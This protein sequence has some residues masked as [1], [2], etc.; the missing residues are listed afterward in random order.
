MKNFSNLKK[1]AKYFH[2]HKGEIFIGSIFLALG[3]FIN[4][5]LPYFFKIV[6]DDGIFDISNSALLNLL[7]IL[8]V[9][10][11]AQSLF[12]YFRHLYFHNVAHKVSNKLRN[13]VFSKIIFKKYDF[14]QN[15]KA[16]DLVSLISSDVLNIQK[17]LTINSSVILR[18]SFQVI[19]SIVLM[20][21]ISP[22]LSLILIS[23]IPVLAII[24]FGLAKRLS[25]H[26]N[27]LQN[28]I[29]QINDLAH[30]S[31]S[32]ITN[33]KFLLLEKNRI[34]TFTSSVE[35]LLNIAIK[36]TRFA[37]F[38]S[39]FMVFLVHSSVAIVILIGIYRVNI[40]SMSVGDL[41]AFL[42]YCLILAMSF[43]FII[44]GFDDLSTAIASS[45][46]IFDV[47]DV[48]ENDSAILEDIKLDY[49]LP[50]F[51]L[52]DLN[53]SYSREIILEDINLEFK[54][55]SLNAIVGSSGSG[56]STLIKIISK[57][58]EN[59]SGDI[60]FF[61]KNLKNISDKQLYSNI[62]VAT[63]EA[64]VFNMS[65]FE[66]VHIANL[67]VKSDLVFEAIKLAGL[68]ELVNS[69]PDKSD[70]I[71]GPSF[72]QLSGGE[73]Q[74]LQIARLILKDPKVIIMD[75]PTSALDSVNEKKLLDH[76]NNI[77]SDKTRI[78]VSHRLNSIKNADQIIVL[79]DG[80]I[81][82]IGNHLSLIEKES[83]YLK[84]FGQQM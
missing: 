2:P 18:Y 30:E 25:K 3:A 73:K 62:A 45:K 4:I 51:T 53:F 21:I 11:A 35:A 77:F 41:S 78:I 57:L 59:Y 39:S 28:K 63:Q 47:I 49:S 12:F 42:I 40:Q 68:E 9:I 58:F 80:L 14:F 48:N 33:I 44:S 67:A 46:R 56:K 34:Q 74:K 54:T 13:D 66:N 69:L 20:F 6:I 10:F 64:E 31:F 27:K 26:S 16:N 32:L 79:Q 24:G 55:G 19:F 1:L 43:G 29:A 7:L 52:K 61:G 76:I 38:F 82:E 70:T 23:L 50:S 83:S 36:R 84:L 22:T 5:S 37:A 15:I 81:T 75:E 17:S 60:Y 72:H 65:I 8:I 71:I